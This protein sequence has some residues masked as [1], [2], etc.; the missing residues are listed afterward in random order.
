MLHEHQRPNKWGLRY[1]GLGNTDTFQFNCRNLDSFADCTEGLDDDDIDSI[2]NSYT[3]ARKGVE[4]P[5]GNPST[6]LHS[7]EW[8]PLPRIEWFTAGA[9]G[10]A[11]FDEDSLMLYPS[12]LGGKLGTGGQKMVVYT[13]ADGSEFKTN[14]A[15]SPG[16][17]EGLKGLYPRAK[18]ADRPCLLT[19]DCNSQQAAFRASQGGGSCSS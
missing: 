7:E 12:R 16:D 11:G 9:D 1:G 6:C 18:P 2:C 8:L 3:K 19:D 4:L 15:P 17:V 5:D 10:A 13:K 14:T